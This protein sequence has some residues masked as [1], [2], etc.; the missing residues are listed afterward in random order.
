MPESTKP[1]APGAGA[2][3]QAAGPQAGN[4]RRGEGM[5]TA[6]TTAATPPPEREEKGAVAAMAETGAGGSASGPES[7]LYIMDPNAA[8]CIWAKYQRRA[9]YRAHVFSE[10]GYD[11][12]RIID[13]YGSDIVTSRHTVTTHKIQRHRGIKHAVG[14]IRHYALGHAPL[15]GTKRKLIEQADVV[16]LHGR[17]YMANAIKRRYPSKKV[18]IHYSG[19]DLRMA[20]PSARREQLAREGIADMVTV[21]TADLLANL[22]EKNNNSNYHWIPNPI[23]TEHFVPMPLPERERTL[24]IRNATVDEGVAGALCER[25]ARNV[26]VTQAR[27]TPYADMPGLFRDYTHYIDWMGLDERME[28][29]PY[30]SMLGLEAM[31]CGRSVLWSDMRVHPPS[32]FPA[33]HDPEA[34]ARVLTRLCQF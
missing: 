4:G 7:F 34:S 15:S 14:R 23:D 19:T 9:G 2:E 30:W 1:A 29:I 21:S 24:R 27:T 3:G 17:H 26:V 16:M 22:E 10:A 8:P 31:A 6:A 13:F 20:S 12:F 28:P 33:Q 5:E 18:I 25:Y 32:D 11:P